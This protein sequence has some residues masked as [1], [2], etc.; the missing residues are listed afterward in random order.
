MKAILVFCVGLAFVLL[1][2]CAEPATPTPEPTVILAK[3]PTRAPATATATL[4]RAT[5]TPPT[6]TS[7]LPTATSVPR[8]GD[9]KEVVATDA[10][11]FHVYQT[12]DTTSHLYQDKVYASGLWLRDPK[13][14]QPIPGMAESW[15]ISSD[16][17]TYTFKLRKDLKWSD[18][19]PLTANDF[20]WTFIQANTPGNRYPYLETF[21]NIASFKATDDYVLEVVLK[22]PL[23]TGLMVADAITPLPQHVWSNYSWSDPAKNPEI[24][25]PTV[26]SGPYKLKEWKRD[27]HATFI[28][29]DL[30]YRG[31]P[32]FD[33]DTVRIV[34]AAAQQL[35]LLKSGDVDSAPVGIPDY[36]D[37]KKL[38]NLKSYEWEPEVPEWDFIGF[39]L[40]RPLLKDVQ[41]RNA[42]SY[43]IPRQTIADTV[44][45][46]L[47]KPM[48]SAYAPTSWVFNPDVVR[49]DYDI[50]TAKATLQK[51]G[52]KLNAQGKLLDKD[53][54]A[55]P[56]LKILYNTTND[57]R[58]QVATSAQT[59]FKKLGIDADVVG[60]EFDAYLDYIKKDPF[61]YDL[62]ILG[63]RTS[64][65]PYFS[66]QVWSQTNIPLLNTGAYVNPDV[67]KLFDQSNHPPCDT[68]SR[69]KVFQQIQKTISADSPYVF[70]VY[71]TGFALLNKR[72]VPNEPT[73]LG[74]SYFPEQW[75]IN[76]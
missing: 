67:D 43:A 10:K 3:V 16:G 6:A 57:R 27:D 51:A 70:L 42:L 69:K 62:Y 64:F 28:R 1:V 30:Y 72:I 36:P 37:A 21:S 40:R 55:I 41:V 45:R 26:V 71:Q 20:E 14:M 39:N 13:T 19:V 8:G 15:T 5:A 38:D 29:N 59:E 58:K 17:R 31:A 18:G 34:P 74:I 32:N 65:D 33:S 11:S 23:C 2:A 35:Q 24:T 68:D 9:F 44:Y 12:T 53:G 47:A 22:E 75:Y 48:F 66:Y 60:M 7:A 73:R 50:E 4:A 49:Y 76:K 56:R 46:G 54:K 63:W 52:Y 61:D 25:N